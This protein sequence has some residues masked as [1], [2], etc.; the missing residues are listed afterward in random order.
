MITPEPEMC[1]DYSTRSHIIKSQELHPLNIS[2]ICLLL[3]ASTVTA[4]PKTF[5]MF[6]TWI[7]VTILLNVLYKTTLD[8]P[9]I[10]F[11]QGRQVIIEKKKAKQSSRYSPILLFKYY[12]PCLAPEIKWEQES[13]SIQGMR[14]RLSHFSSLISSP[15][16]NNT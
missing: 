8:I 10:P 11:L 9:P 4:L 1:P 12:W 6:L 2:V 16:P 3:S 13:R 14:T 15:S 7:I 5:P